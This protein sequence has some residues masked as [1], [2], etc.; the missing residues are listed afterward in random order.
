MSEHLQLIEVTESELLSLDEAAG[1][2]GVSVAEV[3][4]LID[5]GAIREVRVG[6]DRRVPAEEVERLSRALTRLGLLEPDRLL[7]PAQV[8]KQFGV[9]PKTVAGWARSG[10]LPAVRT[11][12]GH[13]RYR[14]SDVRRLLDGKRPHC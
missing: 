13:R 9:K 5:D 7:T 10:R 4:E 8:A 6:T 2:L 1:R 3:A 14:E 11:L 12:G